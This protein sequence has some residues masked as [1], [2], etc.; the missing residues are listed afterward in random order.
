[1]K[2]LRP[3]CVRAPRRVNTL[4]LAAVA[5]AA[6]LVLICVAALMAPA[7]SSAA[8]PD[9]VG[10]LTVRAG[11]YI[12][13][14]TTETFTVEKQV[15]TGSTDCTSGG[16]AVVNVS[17]IDQ[18]T[19]HAIPLAPT[20]SVLLTIPESPVGFFF[21][22]V[23]EQNGPFV[24][25]FPDAATLPLATFLP[26]PGY[27][28][29]FRG[30]DDAAPHNVTANFYAGI[31]LLDSCGNERFTFRP[32]ETIQI[33][34]TGGVTFNAEP[35]RLQAAGGSVNECTFIPEAPAF[36]T[37]HVD[38]DPF[39]YT[40]TLP[41]SDADILPSCAS[42]GTQH[43][44]GDW[45]VVTYDVPG[46][47]CNRNQ[48]NFKVQEDAPIQSCPL[49]GCPAD[50]E[51]AA[52]ANACGANVN[53]T[54]PSGAPGETVNCD[55]TPG[56]FFPVGTT[57]VT[58]TGSLGGE[59]SFDVT[60]NDNTPPVVTPPANISAGTDADSCSATNIVTGTATAT[61]NCAVNVQG[62]RDDAQPL[63]APYPLGTT[64]ITWT[65]TDASGN[66]ASAQQTVTVV[67]DDPPNVSDLSA[68]PSVLWP[69]NHTMRDVT[70]S[71]AATDNCGTVNCSVTSVTSNEPVDGTGDGD[72]A[73][74][75]DIV[76]STLVH[77]RA[78]R[79]GSGS[80]RRYTIT[81]TCSDGTNTASRS[82]DVNVPKSQQK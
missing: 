45:R 60:V 78:E 38:T 47:G 24:S 51:Q 14:T 39:V 11:N 31:E 64:T 80:G 58:C 63:N 32:G 2:T 28:I 23:S 33:R 7:P 48:V 18:T 72:T 37:V 70:L 44:T 25:W 50:I 43:I 26:G 53:F 73:P 65:A 79:S 66:S 22:H 68:S 4:S 59:C 55:H 19:G 6:V 36:T 81:L 46:C 34:V 3:S 52:A 77:L 49:M 75:F 71:Y 76:S 13:A 61:D 27:Q 9:P 67:D 57:T 41:D 82:V 54:P 1:M 56:S 16:G 62:V 29:C 8:P 40:F 21:S 17:G 15:F 35:H 5:F 74:D 12:G 69:P 20:D 42:S 10:T 30:P